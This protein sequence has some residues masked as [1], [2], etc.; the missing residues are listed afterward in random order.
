M[1]LAKKICR[2]L[3]AR[4]I[5]LVQIF[6]IVFYRLLSSNIF[7]GKPKLWQPLHCM[8]LGKV[9]FADDVNIGVFPSPFYFSTYA[10]LEAR[11]SSARISIGEGTWINNNFCAIAEH[12]SI[13]IGA[14]CLIGLN[15]EIYD[16]N[17]HGISK[18]QRNIS[19]FEWSSPVKIG[20]N[21][22]IG[23]NVKILKGVNIGDGSVI[24]CS[25]IVIKDIPA[26]VIAAG[27][28]AKVVKKIE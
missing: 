16:S 3:I 17:F 24:A 23:S 4:A 10:Y 22:F 20:N 7:L 26:G 15:V 13:E 1:L 11:K 2:Y 19:L 12:S 6:R 9:L 8:G 27:N 28:P 25:S 5:R 18:T 21:V 14:Q